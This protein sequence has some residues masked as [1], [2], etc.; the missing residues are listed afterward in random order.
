[1]AAAAAALLAERA[2]LVLMFGEIMQFLSLLFLT[3]MVT[4][5]VTKKITRVTQ[6][7][8]YFR[9][10]DAARHGYF[11]GTLRGEGKPAELPANPAPTQAEKP[12]LRI[13]TVFGKLTVVPGRTF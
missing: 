11:D 1:M 6:K 4:R 7:H 5:L 13:K 3:H 9:V 10:Q 12:G 2:L 8:S